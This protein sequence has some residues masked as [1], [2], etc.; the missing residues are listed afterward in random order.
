[1]SDQD[2][3]RRQYSK[4]RPACPVHGHAMICRHTRGGAVQYYYCPDPDCKESHKRH[5]T[6][7]LKT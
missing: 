1:M 7:V 4:P 6:T 5:R 3:K 2:K